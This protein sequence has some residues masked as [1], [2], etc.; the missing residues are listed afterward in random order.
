MPSAFEGKPLIS[1]SA[2]NF[3]AKLKGASSEYSED[4]EKGSLLSSTVRYLVFLLGRGWWDFRDVAAGEVT[5]VTL[6]DTVGVGESRS[7]L[8]A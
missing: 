6:V 4:G 2:S 8:V 1:G 5:E 3:V 7:I